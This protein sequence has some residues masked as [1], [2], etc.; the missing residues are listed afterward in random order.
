MSLSQ[1]GVWKSGV[2]AQTVWA[3]GVWFEGSVPAVPIETVREGGGAF[4]GTS[5]DVLRFQQNMRDEQ[6]IIVILTA[7]V[8]IAEYERY[9]EQTRRLQ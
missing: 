4:T 5:P 9:M 8:Q 1:D 3:D 2:W 7:A 6:E